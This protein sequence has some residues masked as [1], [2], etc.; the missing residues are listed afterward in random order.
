MIRKIALGLA[1]ASLLWG[2]AQAQTITVPGSTTITGS[3]P[4]GSATIGAVTNPN[5]ATA[6]VAINVSTATTTQLVALSS[7]KAIY[8]SAWDVTVLAADNIT[9]EYG[10]GSNCGTGTTT[11]TGAYQFPAGGGISKGSGIAPVL[12]V[13]ASNALCILTSAN[14]QASGSVSYVQF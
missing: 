2:T 1:L 4:A 14:T 3:L 7:G 11:L 5:Q 9:L 6:S 8:V 12:F 10:T 13:P